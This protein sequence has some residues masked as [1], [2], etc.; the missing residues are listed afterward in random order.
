MSFPKFLGIASLLLFAMIGILAFFKGGKARSTAKSEVVPVTI[1]VPIP[2]PKEI[3]IV[4]PSIPTA[5]P[6]QEIP[7]AP[8]AAVAEEE[9]LLP[10]AN[11]IMELFNKGEPKLPFVET[12][13]YKSRVP[14]QKGRP[15]WLVDYAAHYK[16]SRHFI[17]RSLNG[18]PD[19]FDQDIAEGDSFN[20][21]RQDK[22]IQFYLLIDI[23][24]CKMW[25]YVLDLDTNQRTLL[26]DYRV[27]LGRLDNQKAS[28][29][30]TP[31]GKY[32]LGNRVAIYG[33]KTEGHYN[34]KKVEMIRVFG[35]RWIPF[36]KELSHCSAPAK[37]FGL[38]GVPWLPNAAGVLC[39]DR[40]SLG[41]HDSDGCVRLATEDIEELF[42]IILTKP[43]V[44]ELVQNYFDAIPK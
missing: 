12:I 30:L 22:N 15:A 5:K 9:R 1:M 38:H 4:Q 11:R 32:S 24:R 14:W 42:A 33:P 31:L 23:S 26:K 43:T 10:E 40:S 20:V 28:G 7:K 29:S 3:P 8:T 2:P 35:T 34:G 44:V 25:F 41:K 6:V 36:E 17:A 21:L 19:Y 18:K 13:V 27:S 16:T 39:E 37:G